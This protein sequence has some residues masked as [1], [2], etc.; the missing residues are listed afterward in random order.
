LPLVV[1]SNRVEVHLSAVARAH[2]AEP[3][4]PL[5]PVTNSFI[6]LKEGRALTNTGFPAVAELAFHR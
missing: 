4:T 3:I 1:R 5:P 6:Q 2:K